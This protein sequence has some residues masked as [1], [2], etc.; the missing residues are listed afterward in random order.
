MVGAERGR[1]LGHVAERRDERI[2][3]PVGNLQRHAEEHGEDEEQGHFLLLEQCESPQ[4]ERL[5][6]AFLLAAAADGAI[7]QRHGVDGECQPQHGALHELHVSGLESGGVADEHRTDETDGS[8]HADGRERLD[9]IE[10]FAFEDAVSH[11]IGERDGGHVESDAE[12]IER[13][14]RPELHAG[15]RGMG[16]IACGPDEDGG[17]QVAHA[18]EPLGRNPTVGDDADDGGHEDR[19]NT[20]HGVEDADVRREVGADQVRPHRG[21]V[22]PPD[23]VLEEVHDDETEFDAHELLVL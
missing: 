11:G 2:G 15:T 7:G 20:L 22:G 5:D 12:R 21:E 9:G 4:P 13:E 14:E 1:E 16:V 23:G 18:Q 3:E 10:A 6:D 19:D 17:E 8:P